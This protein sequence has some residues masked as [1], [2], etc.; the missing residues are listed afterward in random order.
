MSKYSYYEATKKKI[1]SESK[2]HQEY[3]KRVKALAKKLKI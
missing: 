1:A 2:T 3:E